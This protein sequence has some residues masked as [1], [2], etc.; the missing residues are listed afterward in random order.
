MS[1]TEPGSAA[2]AFSADLKSYSGAVVSIDQGVWNF[3]WHRH[4]KYSF[5][6][7]FLPLCLSLVLAYLE[8]AY[9]GDTLLSNADALRAAFI[10]VFAPLLI[11][12]VA[13]L[14]VQQV[15]RKLFY[16]EL[17]AALAC[18]YSDYG[19][20]PEDGQ[21]F[22]FGHSGYLSKVFSGMVGSAP[23]RLADY[24][25]TTG[26]GRNAEHHP[27]IVGE[28]TLPRPVPSILCIPARWSGTV[29]HAWKPDGSTALP[30]EGDFTTR[31]TVYV[32]TGTEVEALQVLEPDVMATLMDG[33]DRFGFECT[34]S[35]LYLFTPGS[36][37]ESRESILKTYEL[38]QK[39][40]SVMTPE[41]VTVMSADQ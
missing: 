13:Y 40:V 36:M 32:P 16:T 30:L 39:F 8:Y 11:P 18:T 29:F 10:V 14:R 24:T 23:F 6:L 12:G 21:L 37:Q 2:E 19:D 41:L 31:F 20:A 7:F 33:F 5:F 34:G 25:Y 1:P 3:L 22:S 35:H 9:A 28:L 26:Y 15:M 17:A 38:L 4:P 27:Y